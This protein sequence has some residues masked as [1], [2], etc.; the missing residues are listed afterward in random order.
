MTIISVKARNR[1]DF[2]SHQ[3]ERVVRRV[4]ELIREWVRIC[5]GREENYDG[6]FSDKSIP[7]DMGRIDATFFTGA[8]ISFS[9]FTVING[10]PKMQP[11]LDNGERKLRVLKRFPLPPIF[12]SFT[13]FQAYTRHAFARN[14]RGNIRRINA[15]ECWST[16]IMR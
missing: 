6:A 4:M 11:K 15:T 16:L 5:S 8:I 3:T 7:H 1:T 13:F 12:F 2:Y 14:S 9:P 10:E